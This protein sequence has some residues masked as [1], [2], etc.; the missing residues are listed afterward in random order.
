MFGNLPVVFDSALVAERDRIGF[1]CEE[2]ARKALKVDLEV[3]DDA[4]FRLRMCA[5]TY[6]GVRLAVIQS[7]PYRVA[8]TRPL[9]DDGDDRIGLV[10]PLAGR[11]GGEQG[12]RSIAVRRGEAT[13]MASDLTGWFGTPSG[14]AF[15]TI[16]ISPDLLAS[17]ARE[18]VLRAGCTVRPSRVGFDLVRAYL[19]TLN[20]RAADVPPAIAEAAGRH[21]AEIAAHAITAREDAANPRLGGEGLRTARVAAA[22]AHIAAHFAD[23]GYDVAACASHVGVSVRY[24]QVMLEADGTRFGEQ[25]MQLRLEHARR[26]LVDPANAGLR[27]TDVAFDSGFSDVSHFNRRFRARFGESPTSA[28]AA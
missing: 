8:R 6:G 27:V 26:L 2:Y 4:P 24:L 13:V 15:L 25:L 3:R 14:G 16:R 28:R 18:L 20:L 23:P 7:T 19:S 17:S 22:R 9:I 1:A 21:L 10:F 11:F 5:R 12:G